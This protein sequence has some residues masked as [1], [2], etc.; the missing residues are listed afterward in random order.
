MFHRLCLKCMNTCK[1]DESVKIVKCPR[2]Q[3]R[4]SDNE[5]RDLIGELESMETDAD[6]LRARIRNVIDTALA[7]PENSISAPMTNDDS[8]IGDDT[9]FS[10]I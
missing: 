4:L 2:F 7:E 3:K 10:A 9:D 8:D 5:F 6:R 1:Q